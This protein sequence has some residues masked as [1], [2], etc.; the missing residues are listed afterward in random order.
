VNDSELAL[1]GLIAEAAEK[2]AA[3]GY[4]LAAVAR[5]RGMERW[6]GLSASSVYKGLRRLEEAGLVKA[7]PS[8]KQRAK[9]PP[10]RAHK[11]T[12][13]G[14]RA[15]R[16]H[17]YDGLLAAPEQS[18]R[19]RLSL[20]FIEVVGVARSVAQLQR[21]ARSLEGRIAD[22]KRAR[23]RVRVRAARP[24]GGACRDDQAH[25]VAE[26]PGARMKSQVARPFIGQ[27][28]ETVATGT[29]LGAAGYE[30]S[31]PML[32]GLGEALGFVFLNLA[33]LPLPFIGGR[34]KPFALTEALCRNLG[35]PL[36]AQET[37][38]KA[39]A[40]AQLEASLAK[41][42]PVG[43]QL[44]CFYLP[45]FEHAP[46]FAGH[47]VAAIRLVDDGVEVVDTRQQGSVHQVPRPQ[48]ESA[49]H[50]R[51]P[52]AAKAR[53]YTVR[54][55]SKP[56]LA[57][58]AVSAM[59]N[60]AKCYLAPDFA[61]MGAP[62]IAKLARSLPTWLTKAAAKGDDLRLA[63]DLME[64][65]GTG[66][67]LFRNL[68]R[69]FLAEAAE[70]VPTKA[71]RMLDARDKIAR[72]AELWTALADLLERCAH[73]GRLQHLSEASALCGPIAENEVAAM[74]LLASL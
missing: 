54:A 8:E 13:A 45:Y 71:R 20:A 9:G 67:A 74:Q 59:R 30:L 28:C 41:F 46:H 17:L 62:G 14:T 44:D 29:L 69:D 40:W 31:E 64:R 73:D 33:S 10:G 1:L 25:R 12:A 42:E 49:R 16:R 58:A 65:A 24:R 63:A 55:G 51:G 27:H 36:Q 15:L 70:L 19:Y 3:S 35:A 57:A 5:A 52:M 4:A 72:S 56:N 34:S 21:R 22:V 50:A 39:K 18:T 32:F 66:G 68:Y 37:T 60:N 43:L 61:G 53:A 23:A 7:G 38:S 48:L 2:K 47:F 26:H 6:A 11:L